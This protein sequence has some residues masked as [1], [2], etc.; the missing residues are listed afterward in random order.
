MVT[1]DDISDIFG[2]D[3]FIMIEISVQMFHNFV[4]QWKTSLK[5][6]QIG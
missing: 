3:L 6:C 2:Q 5:L 1:P 4:N